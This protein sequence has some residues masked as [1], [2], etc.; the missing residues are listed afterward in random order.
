MLCMRKCDRLDCIFLFIFLLDHPCSNWLLLETKMFEKQV[1]EYPSS[2]CLHLEQSSLKPKHLA[3]SL[4][5]L[6]M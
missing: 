4:L 3:H 5:S 1:E 2:V 6:K